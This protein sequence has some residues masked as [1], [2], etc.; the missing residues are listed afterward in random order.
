MHVIIYHTLPNP[1]SHHPP[2]N[3]RVLLYNVVLGATLLS[4]ADIMLLLSLQLC[5]TVTGKTCNG[6]LDGTSCTISDA[7]AEVV[8]LTLSLL[9]LAFGVLLGTR[10]LEVLSL[11]ILALVYTKEVCIAIWREGNKL[12][13]KEHTSEPTSPPRASFA[14]PMVWFHEPSVRFGSSFVM[15]PD[16]EA[17]K[18]PI[19]A[20]AWEASFSNSALDF[21]ASPAF[22][23][24][25]SF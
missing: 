1:M 5:V 9:G 2:L 4:L 13:G 19:L 7:R 25:I 6:T 18:L 11:Q 12:R 17:E 20:V 15:A 24:H 14:L 22:C 16:E 8:E 10:S 21:L 23:Y 3:L